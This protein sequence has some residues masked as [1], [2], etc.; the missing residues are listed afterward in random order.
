MSDYAYLHLIAAERHLIH[1][2]GRPAPLHPPLPGQRRAAP[3]PGG[4]R[5]RRAGAWHR[6]IA[7]LCHRTA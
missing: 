4:H 5:V 7:V 1:G 6:I 2:G 3:H